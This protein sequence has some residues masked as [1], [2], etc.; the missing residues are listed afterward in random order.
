MNQIKQ[1]TDYIL[2]TAL[3]LSVFFGASISLGFRVI[4][5]VITLFRLAIPLLFAAF[6]YRAYSKKRL[7]FESLE[8]PF[9][10]LLVVWF[11]YAVF[12]MMF[13][14]FLTDKDAIK[15]LLQLVLQFFIAICVLLAIKTEGMEEKLLFIC[16]LS[17]VALTVL[18]MFEIVTGIHLPTSSYY[19]VSAL[20]NSTSNPPS[21]A[22]GIFFNEND[23]CA[24]L[25]L[26]SPLFFPQVGKKL[27]VNLLRMVELSLMEFIL[28]KDDA[29]ICLFG[30]FVGLVFYS[31]F[32]TIKYRWL[33]VGVIYAVVLEK[34]I[35]SFSLKRA[36]GKGLSSEVKEQF[37]GVNTQTGSAY[38]RMHTY[39]KEFT[40]SISDA[41][42][43]GFGPYGVNKFLVPFDH[44]YVLS[45]PHSLWLELIANY[46]VLIFIFFVTICI[47]SLGVLIVCGE[48]KDPIRAVLIPMDIIFVI[49]G[50]ASSNY[51]GIAY[52]WM[53][54][55]L[56]V[57]YASKLLISSGFK[58]QKRYVIA[59]VVFLACLIGVSYKLLNSSD[60]KF[61]FQEPFKSGFETEAKYN[62]NR[63]TEKQVRKVKIMLDGKE[64]KNFDVKNGEFSY[65]MNLAGL[66][67][68]WHY[69]RYEY[70][71]SDG[72]DA[73]HEGVLV[74]KV[75]NQASVLIP[76]D[77]ALKARFFNKTA[78]VEPSDF[79]L[80]KK[81]MKN[82]YSAL[83]AYW[84]P[85][86]MTDKNVDQ[87]VRI[88]K[89]GIPKTVSRENRFDYDPELISS[90]ALMWYSDALLNKNT[91]SEKKF[92]S[93]SKWLLEHQNSD[94]SIPMLLGS[95]YREE[96]L[97]KGWV[98]A[99]VQGK[100]LS[101]FSRAYAI[102]GDDSYI[103][104]GDKA[105]KYM[106][107]KCLRVYEKDKNNPSKLLRYLTRDGKFSYYEDV[108]GQDV[109][110]RLDTQL[111][112]LI[113]LYDWKMIDADNSSK[114]LAENSFNEGVSMLSRTLAL[115]DLNGYLAG[116][117][118]HISDRKLVGLDVDDKFMKTIQM[119]RAVSEISGDKEIK[120]LYERYSSFTKDKFYKQSD[121]LI[122]K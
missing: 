102:T 7:R 100:A 14:G 31:I 110:Y 101:V 86:E 22:T 11:A 24:C 27:S 115:Y 47:L 4:G 122:H 96:T 42:G 99:S 94:G 95:R 58:I 17:I 78:M 121:K 98:S 62:F 83:G 16:K 43:L 53:V 6:V 114:K 35:M 49:V 67:N 82:A 84:L 51:I 34:L 39:I 118:M 89:D 5:I 59:T 79:Y 75:N 63:L 68:G 9:L 108:S 76:E 13:R 21:V 15:E 23:Y 72:K 50:F 12:L 56:S 106:T 93:C 38:V 46:G 19:D 91:E 55:A 77:D 28:L 87:R 44:D 32:A 18:G 10:V 54:I 105:I 65:E 74:N 33:V 41:K 48:R 52:W 37:S 45:N 1:K 104:A 112:V 111:Y 92:I 25:A 109:H 107:G 40:H 113:G 85:N 69:Y 97:N 119:L 64:V 2:V 117:L 71:E 60:I 20:A 120:N 66:S 57:G 116:D 90:Y 3:V 103:K 81:V 61:K 30:I 73:G 88:D 80:N 29:I 70:Y 8:K 26:F 36:S